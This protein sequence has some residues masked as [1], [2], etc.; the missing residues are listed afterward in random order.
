MLRMLLA[1]VLVAA[2]IGLIAASADAAPV[3]PGDDCA[4]ASVVKNGLAKTQV[5]FKAAVSRARGVLSRFA[6]ACGNGGYPIQ[7]SQCVWNGSAWVAWFWHPVYGHY[8]GYC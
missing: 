1:V 8:V 7:L 6:P 4:R 2:G 5:S 3:K